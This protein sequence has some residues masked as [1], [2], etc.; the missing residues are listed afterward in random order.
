MF[1]DP[2]AGDSTKELN[3]NKSRSRLS[4]R[5]VY[6]AGFL[7]CASLLGFAYYLQHFEAL[8]PCPLCSFQR[9]AMIGLGLV[10]LL[11]AWHNPGKVGARIWS[12]LI[13]ISALTGAGIAA[14]HVWL[15]HLPPNR[16]PDCGPS[17]D[18]I[19]ETFPFSKALKMVFQGSGECATVDWSLL[20]L[21]MPIW[22][23]L[24]FLI[25][26]GLGVWMSWTKT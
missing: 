6:A 15:Q 4:R 7:A 19:F 10:F 26:G 14:R 18:Y 1:N 20:G 23:L 3:L 22:V 12:G 2:Q 21:S 24:A 8:E 16:V 9:L 25:L 13:A 17:L 5:L 11:A